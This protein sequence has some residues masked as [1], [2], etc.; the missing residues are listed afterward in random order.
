MAQCSL[1][2]GAQDSGLTSTAEL[3]DPVA[4]KFVATSNM[5][6]ARMWHYATTLKNGDVMIVGGMMGDSPNIFGGGINFIASA[7]LYDSGHGQFNSSSTG[8]RTGSNGSAVLL[9]N[10]KV[11]IAGGLD[12]AGIVSDARLYDPAE[13]NFLPTGSMTSAR[14][15]HRATLLSDGRV[16]VTGGIKAPYAYAAVATAE[17]YDPDRGAFVSLPSM[18]AAR[19]DHTSTLLPDGEVLIAGGIRSSFLGLSSAELFHPAAIKAAPGKNLP[20]QPH[21]P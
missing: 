12:D 20:T 16:L 9:A 7:E 15:R 10:G 11:L 19:V 13:R 17:L 18:T 3:Y 14:M 2:V 4:G 1:P 8:A 5:T 21:S 6:V